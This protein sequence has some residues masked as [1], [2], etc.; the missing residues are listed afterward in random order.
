MSPNADGTN[1]VWFVATGD[2]EVMV[3]GIRIMDRWG[4]LVF[5]RT[6]P[7][8][9]VDTEVTWDGKFGNTDLQPGVYVYTVMYFQDGRDRV[10]NGDI[11]IIK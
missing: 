8:S 5:E 9:P 7:Y 4:N 6:E 1:D 10:R 3:N 11:T 2:P